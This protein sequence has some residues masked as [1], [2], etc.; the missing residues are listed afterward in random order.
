MA[1][2]YAEAGKRLAA[3]R[4]KMGYTQEKLGE[5]CDLGAKYISNIERAKSIP[6]LETLMRLCEALETT[7]DALLLGTSLYHNEEHWRSVAQ[8]LRGLTPG[9]LQLVERFIALAAEQDL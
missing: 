7:P 1:I 6:S 9:Q 5:K 4:R 8:Q 3:I 2:N